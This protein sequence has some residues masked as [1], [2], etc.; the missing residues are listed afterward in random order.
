MKVR[1][2]DC[3][4]CGSPL[5]GPDESGGR[6]SR[7][8]CEGCKISAESEMRRLN[9]SLRKFEEGRGVDML[10]G[11]V[12]P[13]RQNVIAELQARFDHL[14]GVPKVVGQFDLPGRGV[15]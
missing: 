13:K 8:C 3:V 11:G 5:A 14:A 15:R 6:P 4:K 12:S 1:V 9:V 7:F 2:H 10:N